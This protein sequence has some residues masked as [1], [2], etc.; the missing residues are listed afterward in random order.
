MRQPSTSAQI[1]RAGALD[2]PMIASLYDAVVADAPW[3]APDIETLLT[4]GG[5]FGVLA[6]GRAYG[7]IMPQGFA[8]GRQAADE[9]ELLAIGVLPDARRMG[10]GRRLLDAVIEHGRAHGAARLVLEV[11][12]DNDAALALYRRAGFAEVARRVG[13]YA[14]PGDRSPDARVLARDLRPH[15]RG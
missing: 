6:A 1:V 12:A 4:R 9:A 13:Y 15:P 8:L 14:T 7:E 11:R 3:H 5:G 2:A 10:V